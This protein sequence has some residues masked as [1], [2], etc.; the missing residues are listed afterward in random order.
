[1]PRRLVA[2]GGDA[3]IPTDVV[4]GPTIDEE[5]PGIDP[6][7]PEPGFGFGPFLVNPREAR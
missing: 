5:R 3:A 7:C 4:D 1:M 2:G 6:W